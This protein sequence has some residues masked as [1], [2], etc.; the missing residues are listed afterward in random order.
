VFSQWGEDGIIQK[1]ISSIEIKHNT[2][3]EFGV[4]NYNESNSRFL[5]INNNWQGFVMDSSKR[6]IDTLKSSYYYWKYQIEAIDAF[7]TKENINE[8]LNKSGFDSDLGI[9]SIDIDG[10]D[11]WVLE[12]INSYNPR[13]LILEYNAVFGKDRKITVP[14]EPGFKRHEKHFSGLFFGA[15]LAAL[16]HL[17]KNKGY[18]LVGTNL[19]GGNAFFVR[20]DLMNEKLTQVSSKEAFTASL[21]RESRDKYGNLSYF[22]GDDRLSL[23]KGMLVVNV[24]NGATEIL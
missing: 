19:A 23:I 15:S 20:N 11:Y 14:Y 5:M 24:E 9:L 12:S 17:A 7:I 16:E 8:L 10:V 18:A 22:G 4:G 3:I 6:E 13:I 1:L 21:A 2:F